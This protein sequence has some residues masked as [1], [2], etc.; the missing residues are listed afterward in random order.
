MLHAAPQN[1]KP[2]WVQFGSRLHSLA[3]RLECATTRDICIVSSF[4]FYAS[5]LFLLAGKKTVVL[6]CPIK[7]SF[8]RHAQIY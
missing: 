6:E 4:A 8:Y 3:L 1:S 7:L 5:C 2:P